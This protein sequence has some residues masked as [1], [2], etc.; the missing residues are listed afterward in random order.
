MIVNSY[1]KYET[2]QMFEIRQYWLGDNKYSFFTS[3]KGE[4]IFG[5]KLDVVYFKFLFYLHR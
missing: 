3:F 4:A 2:I 5:I 1:R